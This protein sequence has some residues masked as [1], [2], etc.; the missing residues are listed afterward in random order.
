MESYTSDVVGVAFEGHHR[1]RIS[2]LDIVEFHIVATCCSNISLIGRDTQTIDLGFRVLD[3]ARAD[4]RQS[5][6]KTI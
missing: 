3:G 5:L 4:P 2:G 6:P 1:I